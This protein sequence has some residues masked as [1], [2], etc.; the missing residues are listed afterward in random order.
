MGA[1]LEMEDAQPGQLRRGEIVEGMVMG[2]SP[3]GLIV[4]VGTKT[5]A[6]IPQSEMLSLGVDGAAKLKAGDT[7]KVMVLQPSSSEG[8]A[9]V[10]LD[11][12]RGEEGWDTLAVRHESGE[13]FD[14]RLGVYREPRAHA[15][16]GLL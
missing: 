10:S 2:A 6:V 4:D 12:A 13:I 3:D 11:R 5:E 14:A 8:H 7:V 15:P 1:L 16:C 9:I